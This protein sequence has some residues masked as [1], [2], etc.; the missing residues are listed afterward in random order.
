MEGKKG[1]FRG[2]GSFVV[3]ECWVDGKTTE[4]MIDQANRLYE[5]GLL[6]FR[7]GDNERCVS[8][9]NNS[10]E[11]GR[12]LSEPKIIGQ[13]LMG[14]CRAVLRARD[15][16]QLGYLSR[17]L[18][19]LATQTGDE[20]WLVVVAH[21]NAEMAR[22]N[23]DYNLANKLYDESMRISEVLGR[24]SMVATECFNK[25][26][27]AIQQN[28]LTSARNLIERHFSIRK[29][30]DGENINPYGLIAVASLLVAEGAIKEAA[31]AI[32][33]CQRLMLEM[34]IIPDPADETIQKGVDE[35]CSKNLPETIRD[36]ILER[37]LSMSCGDV[38][39]KFVG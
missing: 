36:Q 25:S 29:N 24:E 18:S 39:A 27:V 2:E 32:F 31:E 8:L 1:A 17:E 26:L 20:W 15:E 19:N 38:V 35:Y 9:T 6:A 13:A 4:K 5:E 12:E 33:V 7:S 3:G 23:L 37:S 14:L 11:I 10:L 28:N 21:M 22:I 34:D 16:D 30:L